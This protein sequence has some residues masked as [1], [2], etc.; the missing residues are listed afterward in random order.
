MRLSQTAITMA[1][2]LGALCG[3]SLGLGVGDKA[4]PLTI[5]EW[6]RGDSVNTIGDPQNRV[7]VVEFWATWCPP[8][9]ASV[10]LLTELQNQHKKDL[11]II[12]V[13]D[14]D[15]RGN[16][17]SAIRR[18]VRQQGDKM[19]YHVAIDNN[20]ATKNAYMA[21]AGVMGIP[22]AFLVGRDGRIVWQGS[23]LDPA[24]G[25]IIPRVIDGS[26]DVSSAQVEEEVMRRL[27]AL[28]FPIQLEQWGTVWDGL[29]DILKIDPGN[30]VA[31]DALVNIYAK[32][33]RN[34]RR[35]RSWVEEHIEAHKTNI[36]AMERLARMLLSI[37]DI[38]ARVP[39][40]AL[41]ASKAAYQASKEQRA[42]SIAVYA[43][44]MYQIGL[45][46]RA[47]ALQQSAV[48]AASESDRR[49]LARMLDYYEQCKALS[50][51]V[52]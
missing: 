35:F 20:A 45:L 50:G 32:E 6:V 21:A 23:P 41:A 16:T 5:K 30:E 11:V 7:F 43:Q 38:A 26:Y 46:D 17:E 18:F 44:A 10:P 1:L 15:D 51:S 40:L 8:C 48:A 36:V 12:G 33:L 29:I 2:F 3:P 42:T 13:T 19:D 34:T 24:L 9:K 4:P 31:L 25:E 14:P 47:I 39:D 37:D 27:Q 49:E 28:S 52:N 22:H